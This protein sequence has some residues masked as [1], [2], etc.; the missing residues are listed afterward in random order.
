[1]SPEWLDAVRRGDLRLLGQL[2][3]SGA[4]VNARDH[5]G[6]T[7]LMRAACT[8]PPEVVRLLLDGIN[9]Q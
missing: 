5:Y 1:M 2:L 3:E 7:A 8:G 9:Q 6:Q 4:D